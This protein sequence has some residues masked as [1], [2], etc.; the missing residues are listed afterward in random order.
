[1]G[2]CAKFTATVSGTGFTLSTSKGKCA[3][4]SNNLICASTVTTATV[5]TVS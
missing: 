5:F 4:Q 3:I 1:M 2:T